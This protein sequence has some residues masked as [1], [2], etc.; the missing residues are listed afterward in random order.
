MSNELVL[1]GE[2]GV[3]PHDL[4]PKKEHGRSELFLSCSCHTLDPRRFLL[5]QYGYDVQR[6]IKVADCDHATKKVG[7]PVD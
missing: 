7:D 4:C 2:D 6:I 3:N 5:V 1:F